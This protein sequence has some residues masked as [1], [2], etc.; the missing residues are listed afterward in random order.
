MKT[1]EADQTIG[2]MCAH[3]G[4]YN[5]ESDT[6]ERGDN[7]DGHRVD[8]DVIA[9]ESCGEDNLVYRRL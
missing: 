1:A 6:L 5:Y 3:C 7:I 9:C 4:E 8:S 2:F